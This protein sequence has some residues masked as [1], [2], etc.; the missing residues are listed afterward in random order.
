VTRGKG[1]LFKYVRIP[2]TIDRTRTVGKWLAMLMLGLQTL[3]WKASIAL[4]QDPDVQIDVDINPQQG[5]G[6]AAW[7]TMWWVWVLIAMFIIV[8]VALTSRGKASD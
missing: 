1:T 6:G 4:A 3:M 5:D 2:M 8:I 7:Y